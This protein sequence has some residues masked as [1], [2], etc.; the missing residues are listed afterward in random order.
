MNETENL[1]KIEA[2]VLSQM[3]LGI[4]LI[5]EFENLDPNDRDKIHQAMKQQKVTKSG[6]NKT[7]NT[8]CLVFAVKNK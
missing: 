1:E 4:V 3:D 6:L 2:G 5:D 8:K 7:F